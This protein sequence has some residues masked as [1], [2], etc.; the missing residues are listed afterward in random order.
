[1][2]KRL[3]GWS[4][5]AFGLSIVISQF[6]WVIFPFFLLNAL[7]RGGWREAGRMA[8]FASV[9][10]GIL[11]APFVASAAGSIAHNSVGQWDRLAR[12]I[13]RPINLSFW[14]S[15]VVRP[16]H[17][18]WVQFAILSGMLGFCWLRGRCGDLADTLRWMIAA[19]IVFILFNVL[20]DGYFYLMLLV[21]ML[22]YTCV[23]NGWWADPESGPPYSSLGHQCKFELEEGVPPPL[24]PP[25]F[26]A[27]RS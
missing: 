19:L 27:S 22:V 16:V 2:Q 15:Y 10:A 1:M 9:A 18:K 5:A 21:P 14:A 26:G 3:F 23:A 4:A 24:H 6:S 17:L 11:M 7:R 8:L 20:V 12:P 13:A 25:F